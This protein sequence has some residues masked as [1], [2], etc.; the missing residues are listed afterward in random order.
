[1]ITRSIVLKIFK[2]MSKKQLAKDAS[3][4]VEELINKDLFPRIILI[5]GKLA[6]NKKINPEHVENAIFAITH[7]KDFDTVNKYAKHAHTKIMSRQAIK[8][9]ALEI[10]GKQKL[11]SKI[12]V[13]LHNVF[14]YYIKSLVHVKTS[15]KKITEKHILNNLVL[16]PG[17]SYVFASA[18]SE[19]WKTLAGTSIANV[20]VPESH[21]K[22]PEQVAPVAQVKAQAQ[23]AKAPQAP[24]NT[25]VYKGPNGSIQTE[26]IYKGPSFPQAS[27]NSLK[28]PQVSPANAS[29]VAKAAQ[30]SRALKEMQMSQA[31]PQ[32]Q[33]QA[34]L[35]QVNPMFSL[36]PNVVP[37][38][39]KVDNPWNSARNVN[40]NANKNLLYP[41]TE[42][43]MFDLVKNAEKKL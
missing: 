40:A 14:L 25:Q 36:S 31:A 20:E 21:I 2:T 33:A 16:N 41:N 10:L 1:M 3:D 34:S 30:V 42:K 32:S 15:D 27:V 9:D 22:A 43:S 39:K 4:K 28:I 6:N 7:A 12:L 37:E 35:S 5:A 26:P 23:V 11:S 18:A 19:Y 38:L 24:L 29:Q 13:Y 8:K 17:L